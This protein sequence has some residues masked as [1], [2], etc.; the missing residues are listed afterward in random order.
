VIALLLSVLLAAPVPAL[1]LSPDS[2]VA[3]G[4]RRIL[5]SGQHPAMRWPRLTDVRGGA[6]SLYAAAAPRPLWVRDARATP[7]ARALVG[8]LRQAETRGLDPLD[9]DAAILD[10]LSAAAGPS[11]SATELAAF[12]AM[13]TANAL[14]FVAALSR[15]RI[16]PALV[17]ADFQLPIGSP[18]VGATVTALTTSSAPD[19]IIASIEPS[20][21]H[22]LLLKKA[23]ANYRVRARDSGLL[24][25]PPLPRRLKPGDPYAGAVQLRR[26][27]TALGD[28]VDSVA[29]LVRPDSVYADDLVQ[30]VR[31]FQARQGFAVDGIIGDSTAARLGRSFGQR[32]RQIE[33]TLERWRWMPR[34][35]TAPPILV[36]VPAFRLHAF[37]TMSDD[38][39]SLLSMNVV[40]GRAYKSETPVFAA[41]MTYLVFSPYWDVPASIMRKEVRPKAQANAGWLARNHMELLRGGTVVPPTPEN[42]AAIGAG[43][44]VRQTPGP[45]NS[46][47]RVKFMLPNAQAIY[48]H[49]TPSRSL[50]ENPRRDYSHGCVRL[51]D[52]AALARFVLRDQPAWTPERIEAAMQ[53]AAPQTVTLSKPIPVFIVYGTAVARESGEV[54]FYGDIYGHDRTLHRL[55]QKGYPYPR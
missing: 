41:D 32:I 50:F 46:L 8:V 9:Y 31:R 10:S 20:F 11:S 21:L 7:A 18:D 53:G 48:L 40:V 26:L 27:L 42:I 55:L 17:H 28:I 22:Y 37:S 44:R 2:S 14:R 24:P 52:P 13:L 39:A 4:A 6:E 47:G 29:P 5:A 35:F 36:N 45:W 49:D 30:G 3:A 33:L 1:R 15:G 54:F 12:D 34:Q 25:L 43:V 23:L 38:E 19:G 16:N 51:V